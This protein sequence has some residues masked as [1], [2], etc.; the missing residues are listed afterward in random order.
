MSEQC[1]APHMFTQ[2]A[3]AMRSL[4]GR[5]IPVNR[6]ISSSISALTMPD[7]SVAAEWQWIHPWVCTMFEI[8][9]PVPP[10]GKPMAARSAMS[11]SILAG[12][13]SRNSMLWRLVKRR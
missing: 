12:S 11:G 13:V 1:T 4:P 9:L 7:A 8:E 10:T 5:S 2:Q 3:S 6:P